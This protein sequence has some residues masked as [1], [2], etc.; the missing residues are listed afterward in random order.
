MNTSRRHH[1]ESSGHSS[2]FCRE[3]GKDK[4]STQPGLKGWDLDGVFH[5]WAFPPMPDSAL[6]L[7]SSE[8]AQSWDLQLQQPEQKTYQLINS[9]A[10]KLCSQYSKLSQDNLT[11]YGL[12]TNSISEQLLFILIF[13]F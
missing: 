6:S 12:N 2:A 8:S 1:I 10:R 3:V 9:A 5:P 4:F 13:F 7:D 11:L